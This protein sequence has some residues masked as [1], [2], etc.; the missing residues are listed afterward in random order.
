M[1]WYCTTYGTLLSLKGIADSHLRSAHES[2]QTVAIAPPTTAL[3]MD[4]G[5]LAKNTQHRKPYFSTSDMLGGPGAEIVKW[6]P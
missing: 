6:H 1:T 4:F 5:G 3:I 2:Y